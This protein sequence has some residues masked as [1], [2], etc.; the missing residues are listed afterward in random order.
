M[1]WAKI[2]VGS[3]LLGVRAIVVVMALV[4]V[5]AVLVA[6]DVVGGAVLSFW[7]I[8][9]QHAE[10]RDS[11]HSWRSVPAGAASAGIRQ[12]MQRARAR[13]VHCLPDVA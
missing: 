9:S 2:P 4:V 13:K 8:N 1:M 5:C 10:S 7:P 11:E 12:S 3:S 6:V